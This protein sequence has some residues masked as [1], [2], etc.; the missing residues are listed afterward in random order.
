MMSLLNPREP[1]EERVGQREMPQ[2]ARGSRRVNEMTTNAFLRFGQPL[3]KGNR[4]LPQE[5][6]RGLN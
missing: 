1:A 4:H 5:R 3:R 6:H 2:E